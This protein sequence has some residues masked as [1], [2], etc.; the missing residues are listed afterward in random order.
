LFAAGDE[1]AAIVKIVEDDDGAESLTW[2]LGKERGYVK[3]LQ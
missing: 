1:K 2:Y 3:A